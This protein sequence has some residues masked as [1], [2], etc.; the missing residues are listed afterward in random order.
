MVVR[1]R[2]PGGG[3]LL[4]GQI[5]VCVCDVIDVVCVLDLKDTERK[6]FWSPG[7]LTHQL[8]TKSHFLS[9]GL[10]L[11]SGPSPAN[12]IPFQLSPS[13]PPSS[14]LSPKGVLKTLWWLSH[15]PFQSQLASC[16]L[17]LSGWHHLPLSSPFSHVFSLAWITHSHPSHVRDPSAPSTILL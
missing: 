8:T 12:G 3:L 1:L 14:A 9:S 5:E 13:N 11:H 4:F 7:L 16:H 10:S 6:S 17:L 15:V 2:G